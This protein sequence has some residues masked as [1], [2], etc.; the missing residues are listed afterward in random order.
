M[1]KADMGRGRAPPVAD[2]RRSI[3]RQ[4]VKLGKAERTETHDRA[5]ARKQELPVRQGVLIMISF[6]AACGLLFMYLSWVLQD[7]E[8]L[9]A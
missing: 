3:G 4:H 5:I 2:H 6:C 9:P 7:D 8:D 1:G